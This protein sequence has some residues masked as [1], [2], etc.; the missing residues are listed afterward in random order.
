MRVPPIDRAHRSKAWNW[1]LKDLQIRVAHLITSMD[2]S[3]IEIPIMLATFIVLALY[4]VLRLLEVHLVVAPKNN[5]IPSYLYAGFVVRLSANRLFHDSDTE[6][7]DE[8]LDVDSGGEQDATAP[9]P[10]EPR[11]PRDSEDDE[12]ESEVSSVPRTFRRSYVCFSPR[13]HSPD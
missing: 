9:M 7:Q 11:A 2:S 6:V 12:E 8:R 13:F 5:A 3:N 4:S 10:W 1:G